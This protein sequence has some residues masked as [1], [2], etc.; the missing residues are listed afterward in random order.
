M[1]RG[2]KA[3]HDHRI[4]HRDMKVGIIKYLLTVFQNRVQIFS[5]I[6]T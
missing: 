4:L 1:V 2:L 5:Y 6:K 3:L